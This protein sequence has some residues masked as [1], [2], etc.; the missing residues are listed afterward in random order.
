MHRWITEFIAENNKKWDQ[1]IT[2]YKINEAKQL[3]TWDNM[4]RKEKIKRVKQQESDDK[5]STQEI[6]EQQKDPNTKVWTDK[7]IE[8]PETQEKPSVNKITDDNNKETVEETVQTT[9]NENSTT[10]KIA[11]E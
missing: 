11:N 10:P 9:N 4:T 7:P 8:L 6:I 1:E 3:E 2:K 5:F